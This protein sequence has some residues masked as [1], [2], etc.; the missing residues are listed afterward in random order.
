MKT[1]FFVNCFKR[2]CSILNKTCIDKKTNIKAFEKPRDYLANNERNYC[3]LQFNNHVA[4]HWTL[5]TSV[6]KMLIMKLFD[7]K[8]LITVNKTFKAAKMQ[9]DGGNN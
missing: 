1:L 6:V 8:I 4:F 9:V 5:R 7:I 3:V 2:L